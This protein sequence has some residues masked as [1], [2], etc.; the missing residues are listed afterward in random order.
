MD[1]NRKQDKNGYLSRSP[2]RIYYPAKV[3][4]K[5]PT[6]KTLP[7]TSPVNTKP[8]PLTAKGLSDGG[9]VKRSDGKGPVG[10]Q[11]IREFE[12]MLERKHDALVGRVEQHLVNA[13]CTGSAAG[14]GD[15][16]HLPNVVT[17]GM[18]AKIEQN[19]YSMLEQ[20]AVIRRDSNKNETAVSDLSRT[21]ARLQKKVVTEL[22][23]FAA[24]MSPNTDAAP[25]TASDSE[26]LRK[27]LEQIVPAVTKAVETTVPAQIESVIDRKLKEHL[28][29]VLTMTENVKEL[30]TKTDR[31]LA[32]Q[33]EIEAQQKAQN[34]KMTRKMMYLESMIRTLG[35]VAGDFI[36][37]SVED[38]LA[39]HRRS[40]DVIRADI[41]KKEE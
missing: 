5:L 29:P 40:V 3:D 11:D 17:E 32:R 1:P 23:Q 18:L 9:E 34:Q 28:A 22:L 38:I 4:T 37:M 21:V 14:N 8:R 27:Q 20:M 10:A 26:G 25:G 30:C 36:Q 39:T 7:L 35:T 6:D 15:L 19:Q 33:T 24:V 16:Q 31:L 41:A 13:L 12:L 2:R